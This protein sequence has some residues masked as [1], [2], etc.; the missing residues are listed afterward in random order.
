MKEPCQK[1]TR[2]LCMI[3]RFGCL[4][5]PLAGMSYL[6]MQVGC[7]TLTFAAERKMRTSRWNTFG[8]AH[9]MKASCCFTLKMCC[10]Q[11]S[12]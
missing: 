6:C 1:A 4:H 9:E 10:S 11:A 2:I 8:Q 3:H 5:H 7:E 12:V